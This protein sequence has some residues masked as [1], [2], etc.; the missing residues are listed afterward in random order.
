MPWQDHLTTEN[1]VVAQLTDFCR[2]PSVST[3]PER[4]DDCRRAAQWVVDRLAAAGLDNARLLE[5]AGPPVATAEWMRAGDAPT[6]MVYGHYDVQPADPEQEWTTPPYDPDVRDGRIYARG[7][8]DD[9]GNMLAPILAAEAHLRNDGLP[10]NVRFFFEGE[11]EIGSPNL[12][13]VFERHASELACDVV[14]SADGFQW[15][16]EQPSLTTALRG[17]CG[18]Q[19][20]VS[21]PGRD[22]HSGSYGGTVR[23]PA[24]ALAHILS[25]MTDDTGQVLVDGF[26]DNVR[27][28][29]D[30][31]RQHI[32][33]VPFDED[34]YLADTGAPAL[35]GDSQFTPRERAWA[36]PSFEIDG[37]WSGA[38]GEGRKAIIPASAHAK[39]SCRL[40]ADQDPRHVLTAIERHVTAHAPAGV[41]VTTKDLHLSSAAYQMDVDHPANT[42]AATVLEELYGRKPY[43]TRT[44]GTIAILNMFRQ[45]LGADTVMFAFGLTDEN[46]HA[47]DEFF[48][49]S[50]LRRATQAWGRLFEV[51]P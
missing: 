19:I 49:L 42:A 47:P 11:E 21:G 13:P 18:V 6:L 38:T 2:I 10:L 32:A 9:K 28:L 46:A 27:P 20:D 45:Y 31:D 33:A 40:V 17:I 37:M 15:G 41:T 8:S 36:R 4:A 35:F 26:Y 39:L 48:R 12:A 29:S 25:S 7:A 24:D 23:N 43:L 51:Y 5:S 16:E 1:D 22:L 30:A 34:Q 44:G 3:D 14:Y 50:S